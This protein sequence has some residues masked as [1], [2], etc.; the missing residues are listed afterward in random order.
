M[1]VCLDQSTTREVLVSS[2]L[3]ERRVAGDG[4]LARETGFDERSRTAGKRLARLTPPNPV[5]ALISYGP[6][7]Y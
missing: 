7:F 4:A 1:L 2:T 6:A 5:G 3:S